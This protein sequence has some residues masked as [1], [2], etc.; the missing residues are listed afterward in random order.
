LTINEKLFF[1]GSSNNTPKH[2]EIDG[3]TGM[4]CKVKKGS[5][6]AVDIHFTTTSATK[7]LKPKLSTK[8]LGIKM[9][10]SVP[11]DQQNACENLR[12]SKCP[13]EA[14]QDVIYSVKLPIL[15]SYP[16]MKTEIEV[17]LVG[18]N[19]NSHSCFKIDG[20]IVN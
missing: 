9:P 17:N 14:N 18:D 3:C 20:Q 13:L 2:V 1:V 8:I 10:L 7:S 15:K 6:L 4:P 12:D 16:S 19:G 5:D 11:K